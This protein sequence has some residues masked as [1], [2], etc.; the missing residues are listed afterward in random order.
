[1]SPKHGAGPGEMAAMSRKPATRQAVA[2]APAHVAL[3][4]A[5]PDLE[6]PDLEKPDPI[7]E[8]KT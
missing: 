6:K 5:K 3:V 2:M 8:K 4:H 7:K 1:V